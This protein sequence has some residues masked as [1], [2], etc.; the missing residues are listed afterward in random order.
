MARKYDR[1]GRNRQFRLN[2][3]R[4]RK[5]YPYTLPFLPDF[6]LMLGPDRPVSQYQSA[7]WR[8]VVREARGRTERRAESVRDKRARDELDLYTKSQHQ[9]RNAMGEIMFGESGAFRATKRQ[10][11]PFRLLMFD[12]FRL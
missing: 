4:N 5:F 3:T 6:R 2:P 8:D 9:I 7:K 1:Y 11:Q 10:H 12:E